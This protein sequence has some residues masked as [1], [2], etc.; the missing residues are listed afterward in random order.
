[1]LDKIQKIIASII[2]DKKQRIIGVVTLCIMIMAVC[3]II[4]KKEKPA[5]DIPFINVVTPK[6]Q[7]LPLTLSI[8]STFTATA[9]VSVRNRVDGAIKQV[10]FK[11]GQPVKEGALLIEIDDELLQTQLRQAEATMAKD[12]AALSQSEKELA[13]N[14]ELAKRDMASKSAFDKVEATTKGLRASV[15]SDQAL[16]DSLKIQI[17]YARIKSPL[18]GVA[19][20]LKVDVGNFV[21]QSENVPLV[22]IKQ[23]DPITVLFEIPER[24]VPALLKSKMESI[25]VSLTDISDK[26]IQA[27]AKVVAFNSGVDTKSGTLWVKVEV[28]NKDLTQRPGMSVVGKIQFGKHKNAITLPV[29]ALQMGQD[30]AFVF[31]YDKE[32]KI[33]TK[34]PVVVKDTLDAVVIIESGISDSDVIVTEGQIRLTNGAKAMVQNEKET[35][36]ISQKVSA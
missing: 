7:T 23:I 13:R 27:K 12:A 17:G 22:S 6:R 8:P 31:T 1:M 28:E 4:S 3:L 32:N 25:N 18:N 20:F 24:F 9:D 14:T 19:G 11:E 21:R 16:I 26:P 34:K 36:K 30:G 29:E 35:S 2:L 5:K 15:A 10:H 33:V